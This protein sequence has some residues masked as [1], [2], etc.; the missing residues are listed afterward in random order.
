MIAE[1]LAGQRIAITGGTGFLGTAL[2]ERLMRQ[3]PD[4]EL[5][6]LVRAGET[7]REEI[8]RTTEGIDREFLGVILNGM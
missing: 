5:V 1:Q 8:E 7:C 3:V 2:I 6:L 4:C